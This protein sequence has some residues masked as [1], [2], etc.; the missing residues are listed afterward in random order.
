MTAVLRTNGAEQDA[1]GMKSFV[2]TGAASGIGLALTKLL[3]EQQA[4]V[5]VVVR[6]AMPGMPE[7][8]RA[9]DEGRLR[10]Y[11]GD[12]ADAGSRRDV[13]TALAAGE[14]R[15]DTLFNNAGVS[16]GTL[17]F[18]PQGREL[19]YE[20]NCVAPYVLTEG[21]R[22]SLAAAGGRVVNTVSDALFFHKRYDPETLARPVRFRP[23]TGPYASSKLALALWSSALAPA[24]ADEGVSTVS[25]APGA[26]NTPLIRGP[27]MPT[28]M[29]PLA[30]L[31]SKPPS[32]GAELLIDGATSDYPTGSLVV[33]RSVRPLPFPKSAG[34]TLDIV[35]AA[36]RADPT[37][38]QT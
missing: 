30:W 33:K 5:A 37:F 20:V 10:I 12:L 15:I 6:R 8:D 4:S 19:H 28:L 16:T 18:S 11:R 9:V 1:T 26:L 21:L 32:R 36:A 34:R 29:K 3:L 25:V 31:I 7:L 22:P 14:P 17:Q 24:L 23:I 38:V 27:G 13:V 2:V 35:A